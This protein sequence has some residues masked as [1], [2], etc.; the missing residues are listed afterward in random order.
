[1]LRYRNMRELVLGLKAALPMA[2]VWDVLYALRNDNNGYDLTALPPIEQQT[3]G[4]YL[5]WRRFA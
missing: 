4:H 2:A 5:K 1:M 3:N